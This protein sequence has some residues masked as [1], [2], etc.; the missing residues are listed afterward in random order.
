MEEMDNN[1]LFGLHDDELPFV[2]QLFLQ[3]VQRLL[4]IA[5]KTIEEMNNACYVIG[6][7]SSFQVAC[8]VATFPM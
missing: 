8:A 7:S 1:L 5:K 3:P 4:L 6:N 2:C